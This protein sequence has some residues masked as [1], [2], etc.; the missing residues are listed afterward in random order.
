[1]PSAVKRVY[2]EAV[3]CIEPNSL[4]FGFLTFENP[5]PAKLHGASSKRR[6]DFKELGFNAKVDDKSFTRTFESQEL[7]ISRV[8]P[9]R[10]QQSAKLSREESV[11]C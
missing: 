5:I 1:M 2:F 7:S 6:E 8:Q 9:G 11:T 10:L 4:S 3:D